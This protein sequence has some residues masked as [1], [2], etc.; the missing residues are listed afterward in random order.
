VYAVVFPGQGA[1]RVGMSCDF[2]E[3]YPAAREVFEAADQ[4][5]G[6][7]L[8]RWIREGPEAELR[9]TE[10]TQPAI[11]TAT[12]A[13]WRAIEPALPAPPAFFGGHSL[14]EYSA[15][16]AAGG[17]SLEDAVRLVRRRGELMQQ[18]VPE[19]QGAMA[20]VMGLD[21]ERVR[22]VCA[23]TLGTVSPANLNSPAQTVIAGEATA[24]AAATESLREAGARRV[25]PL[26]VSAPFHCALMA[27]AMEKL[28]PELDTTEF[29]DLS[30]PVLSNVTAAPYC[31][32]T[33]IRRLL[34]EQVCAPVRW[35]E[36][37]QALVRL[38]VR[39]ELEIGPGS[40]L[41]GF[42]ARIDRGLR[43]AHVEQVEGVGPALDAVR[44][45][46]A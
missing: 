42:A 46:L 28:G 5:L 20:A 24:V 4:A 37:V 45:A 38:G 33:E 40:V 18:A 30:V 10:V 2:C 11:V 23:R 25:V 22:E 14:G 7:P 35:T 16:V 36:C 44:E 41:S 31:T 26:E 21:P 27:L 9:R 29:R 6:Q 1:Q 13:I 34:R 8:S 17:L 12:I 39:L 3:R 32:A 15:L 19:G 43:R